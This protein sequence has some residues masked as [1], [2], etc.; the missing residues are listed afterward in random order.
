[1]FFEK[2]FMNKL[3]IFTTCITPLLLVSVDAKFSPSNLGQSTE[4][5]VK[6]SKPSDVKLDQYLRIKCNLPKLSN[7]QARTI[8]N[9]AIKA[10]IDIQQN[11]S[12]NDITKSLQKYCVKDSVFGKVIEVAQ[13]LVTVAKTYA[14]FKTVI[15]LEKI[16]S[17]ALDLYNREGINFR[18]LANGETNTL[19]YKENE[20]L[21]KEFMSKDLIILRDIAL[22]YGNQS[23]E[24]SSVIESRE[25]TPTADRPA[26]MPVFRTETSIGTAPVVAE[27]EKPASSII[28]NETGSSAPKVIEEK[29]AVSEKSP[30]FVNSETSDEKATEDS[31]SMEPAFVESPITKSSNVQEIEENTAS[32]NEIT[33]TME[34][35]PVETVTS[36]PN[37]EPI[38]SENQSEISQVKPIDINS[39]V[40]AEELK[41]AMP[42]EQKFNANSDIKS[43]KEPEANAFESP[44]KETTD[45][46]QAVNNKEEEGNPLSPHYFP[47]KSSE[48]TKLSEEET[49]KVETSSSE[50]KEPSEERKSF[51][52]F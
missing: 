6:V 11:I 2:N 33:S 26:D 35:T 17:R 12:E 13:D 34:S 21:F 20:E 28:D 49:P 25:L 27:I 51:W 30:V 45:S 24:T 18:A 43:S 3:L 42:D 8:A 39:A 5:S 10:I 22:Q 38:T 31:K 46:S 52:G 48:A 32:V 16:S 44:A 40:P 50:Q 23:A 47:G 41:E 9:N 37:P 15:R 4:K 14:D 29:E 36:E 19:E 1:M 7:Q